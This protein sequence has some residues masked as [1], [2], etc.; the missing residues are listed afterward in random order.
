MPTTKTSTKS[1][2]VLN[3]TDANFE[4]LWLD[5][6]RRAAPCD[7]VTQTKPVL[8]KIES[9]RKNGD[10]TLYGSLRN[11]CEHVPDKLEL[12]PQE[13]DSG[14][15][16]VDSSDR[17]A[18]GKAA[19]RIREFH[20]KRIPGSWEV[21]E[22]GGA[23]MGQRVRPLSRV[24][25]FSASEAP[26]DPSD[27]IMY[28]TPASAVEV[29]EIFLAAAPDSS[30]MIRPEILM[31][32]RLAGVH[33]VFKMT[34][35]E[36]VAAFALG[37]MEVPQVEKLVGPSGSEIEIAKS[38][39][40][41][42]AGILTNPLPRELCIVADKTSTP[43]WLATDLLAH[44]QTGEMAHGLLI[45]HC[46]TLPARVQSQ[47]ESQLESLSGGQKLKQRLAAQF[48]VVVTRS[49]A[50]SLQWVDRYAP[51]NLAACVAKP[52]EVVRT[53]Q[54][55]GTIMMGHYT[56]SAVGDVLA[57]PG[58]VLP[59]GGTSRF[60]SPLCVED[61]LKKTHFVQFEASKLRELGH[62]AIRLAELDGFTARGASIELRLKR[63]RRA[64]REREVAREAEL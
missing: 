36:S 42:E 40:L 16:A 7:P 23:F 53:V 18:L 11:L 19:M 5:L 49:L 3:T 13:W 41:G 10:E 12:S 4:E 44:A 27:V 30:G 21:R 34:G 55:A 20:R 35:A 28:A 60:D 50:G 1:L 56:P 14:C 61:F 37:T 6:S 54:N 46:K 57:G 22:E 51:E 33:R 38:A 2:R 64:R 63:I 58:A 26:L 24:G 48:A 15:E 32:A 25:I 45:T 52:D 62:D 29:P 47:L 39:L 59:S 43:A 31:A 17:A 8:R 9:V